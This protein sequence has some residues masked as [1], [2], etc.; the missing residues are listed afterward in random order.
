[1]RRLSVSRRTLVSLAA[2]LGLFAATFSAFTFAHNASAAAVGNAYVSL[3]GSFTKAPAQAHLSGHH[4]SSAPM[5]V[6]LLLQSRNQGQLSNTISAL[7]NPGSSQYHHW[8]AKGQ[9][10]QQFAPSAT[11]TAQVNSFLK[12]AGLKGAASPSPFLVRATGTTAQIEAAFHTRVNNYVA[13]NGQSFYQND[14]NVQVPTSLSNTVTAVSGLSNTYRL[15]T[16][17][18]TTRSAAQK[19]G[20]AAPKYGAGPGGSGFAPSQISSLYDANP[21]YKMGS[22]GQGKGTTLG[23][24]ELSGYT[25]ADIKVYEKQFFGAS[26]NVPIVNVNVDG[27][28]ITP[29]CPTGDQ[30][31][32][33]NDYSGDIEVNADVETQIAIAPKVDRIIVYNAP[34][35]FLGVT[36]VNEYFKIASDDLASSISSSWGLCELDAGLANAEAESVAFMQ[37]AAQGQSMFSSSGDTGAF[38]CLR[39]SGNTALTVDDPTSQPFVTSVGGTSFGTYDP[40][41]ALHPT[42]PQG[43]ETVW[44]VLDACSGSSYGLSQCA[45]LGAGGGGVSN[46][47][48]QPSFQ[49]GPGVTSSFSQKGPYCSQA[50]TGQQCREV[51]DVSANADEYTP[52]AEYCTGSASTNSICAQINGWFGI[53]GTSLSSPV[54]SSIIGLWNSVHGSRFGSASYGLYQLFRSNNAYNNVFHDITGKFQTENNNGYYPTTTNYDMATGIGTPRIAGIVK[55]KF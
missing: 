8:L 19:Q 50:A 23:L 11:E 17:Y 31:N 49:H 51:P 39:G 32:P 1:M 41:K 30:C 53:G 38:D 43:S 9:F 36:G 5:T 34:N 3:N 4:T 15:H 48:A 45:A 37:M 28:P 42:Y 18:V 21:I 27:G 6:S 46:F 52:Y 25:A 44:N 29:V 35:D 22:R 33:A 13:A 20:R 54:W 10:N 14:T 55:A 40:G 16:N 24:F 7:Y 47:W 26:E 2:I 12:K